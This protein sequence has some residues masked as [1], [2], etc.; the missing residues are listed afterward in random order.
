MNRLTR[1]S[2]VPVL[3]EQNRNQPEPKRPGLRALLRLDILRTPY[4]RIIGLLFAFHFT[5]YLPM[6][7]FPLFSVQTMH[8][9]DQVIGM[10]NAIFYIAVSL[11]SM[12]LEKVTG[13]IGNKGAVAYGSIL[14]AFYPLLLSFTTESGLYLFTSALGGVAWSLFGG[15]IYNYLLE[16]IPMH[17]RPGHLA[18]YNLV[19]NAG[20]LLGSL[21]GPVIA[22][23]TGIPAALGLIGL[24]RFVSGFALLKW[25]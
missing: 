10:G 12:Q 14:L 13:R 1:E 15:A 8:F 20:I 16:N 17:D 21:I 3:T 25:G 23:Q 6:P 4:G 7:V 9:S 11:G 2:L 5:Q 18:W 22:G 24:L 19:F